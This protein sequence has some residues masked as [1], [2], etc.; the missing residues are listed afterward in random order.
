[1]L[2]MFPVRMSLVQALKARRIRETPPKLCS[3][4]WYLQDNDTPLALVERNA[5]LVVCA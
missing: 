5:C 4:D 3:T 1:M 2:G